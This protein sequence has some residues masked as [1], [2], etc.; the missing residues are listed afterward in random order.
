VNLF[1]PQPMF[2]LY[3]VAALRALPCPYLK[4]AAQIQTAPPSSRSRSRRRQG[5]RGAHVGLL[6]HNLVDYESKELFDI[7]ATIYEKK[8]PLVQA[9][10]TIDVDWESAYGPVVQS[11]NPTP[12]SRTCTSTSRSG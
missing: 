2:E 9:P 7:V 5:L 3:G 8:W 11:V 6:G 12:T 1:S 4:V 10:L